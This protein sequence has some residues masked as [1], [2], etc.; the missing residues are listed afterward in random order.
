MLLTGRRCESPPGCS[1]LP[2]SESGKLVGKLRPQEILT[3]RGGGGR[4]ST[5]KQSVS[6]VSL[7]TL[8]FTNCFVIVLKNILPRKL[9]SSLLSATILTVFTPVPW[10]EYGIYCLVSCVGCG[11]VEGPSP[12]LLSP[13]VVRAQTCAPSRSISHTTTEATKA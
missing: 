9:S 4:G 11:A 1:E 8:N 2:K 10:A 13:L 12:L 3:A 6:W 7:Y 5:V